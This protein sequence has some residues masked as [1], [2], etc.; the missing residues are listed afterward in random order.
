MTFV[1]NRPTEQQIFDWLSQVKLFNGLTHSALL[2]IIET[3]QYMELDIGDM[4]GHEGM[5]LS[6]CALVIRGQVE[7][8]RNTY[9]GEEKIFG[10]FSSYQLVAIAAIFM[11]HNRFPMTIRAKTDCSL[12]LIDK[13]SLLKV[14]HDHPIIMQRLLVNFSAKLYEQINNIDWLTSS[15][16]EQRLAAYFLSLCTN[17]TNTYQF[18]LPISRSQLA[19]K[20]GMRYETL[21]RLISSWRKDQII[22]VENHSIKVLKPA[23]LKGLTLP[24]KRSF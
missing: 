22:K 6:G 8:Y 18:V 23:Y 11:P 1:K 7:V 10:I 24:S 20:L 21:S 17:Q 12:L 9:L 4:F 14:C 2:P 13:S 19:T 16:A 3:A 15:S 5:P